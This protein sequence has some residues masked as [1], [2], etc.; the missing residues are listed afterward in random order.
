MKISK[1]TTHHIETKVNENKLVEKHV[2]NP[3]R[4]LDSTSVIK[5]IH[6]LRCRIAVEHI[7]YPRYD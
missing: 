6:A 5:V 2:D 7:Q 1:E 3:E 4:I